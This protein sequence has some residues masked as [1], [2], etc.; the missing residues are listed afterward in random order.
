MGNVFFLKKKIKKS[1]CFFCFTEKVLKF[2]KY[3][4]EILYLL[5]HGFTN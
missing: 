5:Y 1:T 3:I 2:I 4:G